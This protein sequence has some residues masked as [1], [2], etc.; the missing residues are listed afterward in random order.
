MKIQ[1]YLDSWNYKKLMGSIIPNCKKCKSEKL[2]RDGKYGEFQQYKCKDCGFRFSFTS[3]LPRRRFNSKII[4]FAVNMYISTGMSLRTI[5]KKIYKFFK[6]KVSCMTIARWIREF[7]ITY[8]DEEIGNSW[9]A[10]ETAIRIKGKIYWLWLVTDRKTRKIISWHLGDR[11]YE[12]ARIV[13]LKAKKK[14]GIPT[15]ITT[16]GLWDYI[17]AIRKLFWKDTIHYRVIGAAFG[18]NSVLERLN[19]EVKRRIKWFSTFQS[20]ECANHFLENWVNN[21][22]TE[23]VT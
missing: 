12:C 10:D 11:S 5:A 23:K 16:D 4:E 13:L 7:K 19:R 14:A 18:P 22:N 6:T 15:V 3:D 17:R 2:R 21:Y 20:F 9:H 8:I 1:L